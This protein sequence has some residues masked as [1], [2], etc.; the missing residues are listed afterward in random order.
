MNVLYCRCGLLQLEESSLLGDLPSGKQAN[1]RAV[2]DP[3]CCRINAWEKT[4]LGMMM[5]MMVVVMMVVV[6]LMV[7]VMVDNDNDNDNDDDDTDYYYY[8][9][10]N[11]LTHTQLF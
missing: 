1:A 7:I 2:K 3:A 6:M 11:T 10:C 9:Y 8:Y 5:M 4:L